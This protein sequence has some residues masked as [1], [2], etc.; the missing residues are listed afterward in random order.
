[1]GA[2]GYVTCQMTLGTRYLACYVALGTGNMRGYWSKTLQGEKARAKGRLREI[3]CS[4]TLVLP[5]LTTMGNVM[6]WSQFPPST[7]PNNSFFKCKQMVCICM[8]V[9]KHLTILHHKVSQLT[10]MQNYSLFWGPNLTPMRPILSSECQF[11]SP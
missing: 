5:A 7:P 2:R 8:H 9:W 6:L 3:F 4:S 11:I 1:M 10:T